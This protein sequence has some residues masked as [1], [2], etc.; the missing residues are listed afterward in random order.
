MSADVAIA[1]RLSF[2]CL[3]AAAQDAL[4]SVAPLIEKAL[5]PSLDTFYAQVN[6]FPET[7]KFFSGARQLDGAKATQAA[8]W[9][10]ISTAQFD[11]RY[12]QNVRR[13]GETHAR[14]GLE[15]RWYIGGYAL[16]L[17]GLINA[18]VDEHE[19]QESRWRLGR[20]S[21]SNL[22]ATMGAVVKAAMLDMDLSISIYLEALEAARR[23]ADQKRLEA[24]KV[25]KLV[26]E[27]TAQALAALAAGDLTS[28]IEADFAGEYQRLKDDFNQAME[29]LESAMRG[30][31][32]NA[33]AMQAGTGEI[34]QASDDLSRRTEEQAAT[35]EETAAAL[36]EITATVRKAAE[37]TARASAVVL[38]A[39]D[40][41]ERSGEVVGQ[42]VKAMGAI[43]RSANQIGNIIGVIDEIAFQTNLLALNAGVEAARAGEDG[44]GFAVIA[45]EVRGLAQRSAEAAKEIKALISTSTSQV[46]SGVDLVGQTGQALHTIVD[47]VSEINSLI[48]EMNASAQEQAAALSQ[49]NTAVNQIDQVTQQ[50]AAMVEQSRAATHNLRQEAQDLNRQV[51][52]FKIRDDVDPMTS[53]ADTRYTATTFKQA[54]TRLLAFAGERGARPG[55][56]SD[57][58]L[59]LVRTRDAG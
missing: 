57:G 32:A 50:N 27:R 49:V 26:V 59:T 2:M 9:R 39:K 8:H 55:L 52:R 1:E 14:I 38:S 28:R 58:A 15:P 12:V 23:D 34:S 16:V 43:E 47:R 51:T 22:G 6:R 36:D 54:R 19:R 5:G 17:E 42:A 21:R 53:G 30:I 56:A 7:S 20:K 35:L 31:A 46:S 48:G 37:G 13:I 25:Q 33:T 11:D 41:A 24:E 10:R 4:K 40:E 18:L 29:G 3:D 44:K 45:T